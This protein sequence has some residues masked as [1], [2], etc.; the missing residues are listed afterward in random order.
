MLT[1][2]DFCR[3]QIWSRGTSIVGAGGETKAWSIDVPIDVGNTNVS[4][5]SCIALVPQANCNQISQGDIIMVDSVSKAIVCIPLKLL[6][7]VLEI[8]PKLVAADEKVMKDVEEG[9]S[10]QEA[11]KR[12]RGK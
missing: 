12:H 10:V 1:H 11:F 3:L 2:V 4:P 8:L 5:V 7:R 6:S 9:V